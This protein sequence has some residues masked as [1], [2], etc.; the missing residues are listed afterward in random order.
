MVGIRSGGRQKL[1]AVALDTYDTI[2]FVP[3]LLRGDI[4]KNHILEPLSVPD[5]EHRTP[6]RT[7]S[8]HASWLNDSFGSPA[9]LVAIPRTRLEGISLAWRFWGR[10]SK[11][12]L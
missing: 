6:D 5:T 2:T 11:A 10:P 7:I 8:S 9:R 4:T 1:I 12:L 3:E